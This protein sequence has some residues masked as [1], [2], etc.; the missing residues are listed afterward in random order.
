MADQVCARTSLSIPEKFSDNA[1]NVVQIQ[2]YF[3]TMKTPS[4]SAGRPRAT[5][6][7]AI[8]TPLSEFLDAN[9]TRTGLTNDEAAS[10]LGFKAPNLVSMW[11]TGRT[12]VPLARLRQL[13]DLLGVDLMSMFVLW[14]K[15]E[16]LR[17]SEFPAELVEELEG[18]LATR[19]EAVL[20]KAVRTA[21]KNC[22][23]A[24]SPAALSA[25]SRLL[26]P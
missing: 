26:A 17:N 21:T 9:W 7:S 3:L 2:W 11:R 6:F 25:A 4:K 16:R 18:R 23:P 5:S 14:L 19:N 24:F 15:Q 10:R 20:L 12:P 1:E 13:S 8:T 22:D